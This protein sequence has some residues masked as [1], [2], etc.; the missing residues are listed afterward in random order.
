MLHLGLGGPVQ[1]VVGAVRPD[2][3]ESCTFLGPDGGSSSKEIQ[4]KLKRSI[5]RQ[6]FRYLTTP[7]TVPAIEDLRPLRQHKNITLTTAA[8]HLGVWPTTIS[9]LERGIHETTP[10]P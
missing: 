6:I 9:E 5:A 8:N 4:R 7:I 10:S 1:R 3:H 2:E